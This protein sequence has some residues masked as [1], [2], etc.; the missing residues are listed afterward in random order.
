MTAMYFNGRCGRTGGRRCRRGVLQDG[1]LDQVAL[2]FPR[3][4]PGD[5]SPMRPAAPAGTSSGRLSWYG[6]PTRKFSNFR[7]LPRIQGRICI[8]S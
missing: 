4:E 7:Y 1:G 3:S 5:R 8:V 6:W 2:G